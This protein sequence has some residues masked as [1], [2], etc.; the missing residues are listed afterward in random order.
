MIDTDKYE[1]HTT[2][3]WSARNQGDDSLDSCDY[4]YEHDEPFIETDGGNIGIGYMDGGRNIHSIE[5]KRGN[6]KLMADA[7]R[8]LAEV[9]RLQALI[10][11]KGLC[12]NC[13]QSHEGIEVVMDYSEDEVGH[14]I[15][16]ECIDTCHPNLS[17]DCCDLCLCLNGFT[18][19][20]DYWEMK[21]ND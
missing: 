10:R 6:M 16:K 5:E 20:H 13:G 11:S 3:H 14:R 8:L 12:T 21:K 15:S 2:T 19:E 18:I 9:K 1:G 17:T 4:D 7:P